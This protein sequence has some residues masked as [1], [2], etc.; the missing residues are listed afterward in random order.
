MKQQRMAVPRAAPPA[1]P[2]PLVWTFDGPF[3]R[4]LADA[5][6]TLRAPSCWWATWRAWRCCSTCRCRCCSAG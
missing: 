5:D 4:C 1:L 3:E 2:D 6:D